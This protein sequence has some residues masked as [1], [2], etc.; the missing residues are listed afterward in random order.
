MQ[1]LE[2]AI[3]FEQVDDVEKLLKTLE[4]TPMDLKDL[5]KDKNIAHTLFGYMYQ[6]H[7]EARKTD[8]SLIDPDAEKFKSDFG[9]L[10][11][12]CFED[13]I[14]SSIKIQALQMLREELKKAWKL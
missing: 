6:M 14:D 9:K 11:F 10:A 4:T 5:P 7:L 3:C 2:D 8:R 12:P 1:A 13:G